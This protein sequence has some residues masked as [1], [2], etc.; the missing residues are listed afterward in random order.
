MGLKLNWY[1]DPGHA[2]LRV[3]ASEL[4]TLGIADK[5]SRYS[6]MG[7]NCQ[8]AYLEEDCDAGLY[9]R[10]RDPE[11]PIDWDHTEYVT[12]FNTGVRSMPHYDYETVM[13]A[14]T[15]AAQS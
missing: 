13:R 7:R 12:D 15:L 14:A 3:E 9:I 10:A 4:I 6:Y 5:V 8:Y 2:W 1:A 11:G